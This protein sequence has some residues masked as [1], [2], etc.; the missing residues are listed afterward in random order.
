MKLL[1][2]PTESHPGELLAVTKILGDAGINIDSIDAE[3]EEDGQG[4]LVLSVD[5]YDE[6]LRLL[7]AAKVA[8]RFA[9][10]GVN[11]RSLHIARH[12]ITSSLVSL[13]TSDN[14]AAARLVA[15]LIVMQK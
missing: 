2:I 9:D 15:D 1:T 14:E 5:R 7:R 6:A 8:A 12:Q 4:L 11:I 13:V 10:A 3:E